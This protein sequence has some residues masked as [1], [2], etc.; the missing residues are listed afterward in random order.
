MRIS[1]LD[2]EA[3]RSRHNYTDNAALPGATLT[4]TFHLDTHR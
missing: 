1:Q 2:V 3:K 4:V